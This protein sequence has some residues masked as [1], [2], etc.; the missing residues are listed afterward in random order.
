MLQLPNSLP[1][2]AS[3]LHEQGRV[4]AVDADAR[5]LEHIDIGVGRYPGR[6]GIFGVGRPRSRGMPNLGRLIGGG[7]G[8]IGG[9]LQASGK[10]RSRGLEGIVFVCREAMVVD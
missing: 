2:P 5:A 9:G 4:G 6:I 1:E 8:D 7:K 3:E 10:V